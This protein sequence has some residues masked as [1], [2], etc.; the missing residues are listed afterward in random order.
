MRVHS[1]LLKAIANGS[2]AAML[3]LGA[4]HAAAQLDGSVSTVSDYRFRG[5]SLSD[6]HPELQAHLG[7]DAKDGW[8]AGG[9]ASGVDVKGEVR[10]QAQL[11]AYAGYSRRQG[12]GTAWE[13]GAVKTIFLHA[14]EYDYVEGYAGFAMDNAAVRLYFSPE[15]FGQRTRTLYTE[16]NGSYPLRPGLRLLGHIGL[17]HTFPASSGSAAYSA[18]RTD[19]NL[20]AG[21]GLAQWNVRLAWTAAWQHGGMPAP[22]GSS[23][24]HAWVLNLTATF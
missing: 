20:G 24:S 14:A 19:I 15:Y 2:I 9:F 10:G 8:Y 21:A 16:F 6:G 12:S 13:T 18:Y 4:D 23:G 5:V 17:L 7:Y 3:L 22:Y 1:W 11:L